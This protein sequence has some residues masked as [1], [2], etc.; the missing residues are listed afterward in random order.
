MTS[1]NAGKLFDEIERA[2]KSDL[3]VEAAF[4]RIIQFCS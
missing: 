3:S 4:L 2:V 1:Y